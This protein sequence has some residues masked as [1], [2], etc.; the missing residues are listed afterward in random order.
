MT[1]RCIKFIV[2]LT[3]YYNCMHRLHFMWILFSYLTII[4]CYY[5]Y[6]NHFRDVNNLNLFNLILGPSVIRIIF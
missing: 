6:I 4:E 5:K 2:L 1:F 3:L